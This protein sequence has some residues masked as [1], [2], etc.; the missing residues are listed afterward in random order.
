MF[1]EELGGLLLSSSPNLADHHN[2]LC[3]AVLQEHLQ[4]V[5]KVCSVERITAYTYNHTNETMIP[6]FLSG[7]ENNEITIMFIEHTKY[8][9]RAKFDASKFSWCIL[10]KNCCLTSSCTHGGGCNDVCTPLYL[11]WNLPT[12]RDCPSPTLVVCHTA[13]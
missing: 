3:A 10:P 13:S 11:S 12:Q 7:R 4:T 8:Y 6:G 5:H 9:V 2:S 1:L